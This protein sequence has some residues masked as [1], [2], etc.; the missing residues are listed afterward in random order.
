MAKLAIITKLRKPTKRDP[1]HRIVAT[2]GR[3]RRVDRFHYDPK[4]AE[5]TNHKRFALEVAQ[6]I[7]T[8]PRHVVSA[9]VGSLA[10]TWAHVFEF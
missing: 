8:T 2:V 9:H 6:A 5:E 3:V 1:A 10:D 7:M 4:Y